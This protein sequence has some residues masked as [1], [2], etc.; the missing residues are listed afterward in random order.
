MKRSSISI[1]MINHVGPAPGQYFLDMKAS[2]MIQVM[3][4]SYIRKEGGA[5]GK[6]QVNLRKFQVS[7]HERNRV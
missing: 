5:E 4:Y 3:S 2:A 1:H 6:S 7:V